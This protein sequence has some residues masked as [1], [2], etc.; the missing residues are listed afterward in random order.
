VKVEGSKNKR[1]KAIF[2][3]EGNTADAFKLDKPKQ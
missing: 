3:S 1:I 2:Y